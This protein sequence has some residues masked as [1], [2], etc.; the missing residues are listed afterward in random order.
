MDGL[1]IL[2]P[3]A[4]E[5]GVR[6]VIDRSHNLSQEERGEAVAEHISELFDR[7]TARC[8]GYLLGSQIF[9]PRDGS[10]WFNAL[11]LGNWLMV[12][13]QCGVPY[14][15]ARFLAMPPTTS[16]FALLQ[17]MDLLPA[18]QEA[19][20]PFLEA[21]QALTPG[22]MLRF[23]MCAAAAIK[24]GLSDGA[25][26][27]PGWH[28]RPDGFK[29]PDVDGRLIYALMN[30]TFEHVPVF[31]RPIE[32]LRMVD[33]DMPEHPFGRWPREWR[34]F[35]T[36]GEITGVS[37]YYLQAPA[38]ASEAAKAMEAVALARRMVEA[39][40]AVKAWPHH[41]RYEG[42]F[43]VESVTCS[44]DF[45]EREDGTLV[46]MEGGPGHIYSPAWGAHPCCFTPGK[47]LAG[48][49]L[50]LGSAPLPMEAA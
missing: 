40:E 15:A 45:A 41:P 20:E 10:G 33:G 21:L 22:E 46:L 42:V 4:L 31:A 13:D 32:R 36:N 6:A 7:V 26:V 30:Y 23:D 49:A 29:L 19:V 3:R 48:I 50:S 44:L 14:I 5:G 9:E 17:G 39:L 1:D 37:N 2:D 27:Q 16:V 35:V 25:G 18:Q 8:E 47:P 12:A 11:S 38:W 34:V 43:N 24:A 28:T